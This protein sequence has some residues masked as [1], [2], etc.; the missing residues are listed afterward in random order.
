LRAG[1]PEARLRG[2]A[3][4]ARGRALAR[5][6]YRRAADG[7]RGDGEPPGRHTVA[8]GGNRPRFLAR[9][10]TASFAILGGVALAATFRYANDPQER[11]ARGDERPRRPAG[12]PSRGGR[13]AV[14]ASRLHDAPAQS[15]APDRQVLPLA[16]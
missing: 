14:S 7:L 5:K 2:A 12:R 15:P 4:R 10:L 13:A 9:P 16:R 8:G 3:A 1:G 11:H 6:R